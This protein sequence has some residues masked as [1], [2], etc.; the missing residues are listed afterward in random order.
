MPTTTTDRNAMIGRLVEHSVDEAVSERPRH[1][2]KEVFEKGFMGYSKFSDGQLL[3]EMYL[4]GLIRQED[5]DEDEADDD[6]SS[7][8][9]FN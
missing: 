5:T 7:G 1:W 9:T 6:Y 3:R 4:R 8:H 2:L